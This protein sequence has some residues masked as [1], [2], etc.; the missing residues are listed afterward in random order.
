VSIDHPRLTDEQLEEYERITRE[1]IGSSVSAPYGMAM[2]SI[3][4]ELR[5]RRTAEREA[6]LNTDPN[7]C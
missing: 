6:I 5:E 3:I 1:S 4:R 7:W 2:L